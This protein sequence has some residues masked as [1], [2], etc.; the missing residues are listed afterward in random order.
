MPIGIDVG[1]D[2]KEQGCHI[3]ASIHS[4]PMQGRVA[5]VVFARN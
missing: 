3:F 1:T 4:G 2:G 5:I